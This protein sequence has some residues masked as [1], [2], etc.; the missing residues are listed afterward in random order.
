VTGSEEDIVEKIEEERGKPE[1]KRIRRRK[2]E[3]EKEQNEN[4]EYKKGIYNKKQP[5]EF[6]YCSTQREFQA[7]SPKA[8]HCRRTAALCGT[9]H[10]YG[11]E[12]KCIYLWWGT[13]SDGKRQ[14]TGPRRRWVNCIKMYHRRLWWGD[15]NWVYLI[16]KRHALRA[17]ARR[18]MNLLCVPQIVGNFVTSWRTVGVS[19][20]NL[21]SYNV[22][23]ESGFL[24][25]LSQIP[26]LLRYFPPRI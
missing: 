12:E 10:I 23:Y 18:V 11:W 14:I 24:L 15:L 7:A 26:Q 21:L 9:V 19:W 17:F 20:R 22:G 1:K 4:R 25:S 8:D 5:K 13:G 6:S 2:W 16:Q 3:E